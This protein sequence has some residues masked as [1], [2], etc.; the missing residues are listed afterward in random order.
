M[1]EVNKRVVALE[2]GLI[3]FKTSQG[4]QGDSANYSVVTY[5]PGWFVIS[6]N[7]FGTRTHTIECVPK[8]NANLKNAIFMPILVGNNFSVQAYSSY[9]RSGNLP[10]NIITWQQTGETQSKL[11]NENYAIGVPQGITIYSN[12]EF[13]ITTSYVDNVIS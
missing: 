10:Q 8:S 6:E 11:S 1:D 4:T 12:V 13:T 2:Q 3:K 5:K 7:Q 9:G